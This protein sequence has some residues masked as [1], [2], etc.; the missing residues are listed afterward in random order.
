ME[1]DYGPDYGQQQQAEQE[2][3]E[4]TVGALQRCLKAGA[5]KEDVET[6]A[7]EAGVDIQFIIKE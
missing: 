2:R 5:K 6:L 1:D 4:M 3:W 7:R